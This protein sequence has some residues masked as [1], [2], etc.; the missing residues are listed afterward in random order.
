MSSGDGHS[1]SIELPTAAAVAELLE[2]VRE[3]KV[4][5][6]SGAEEDRT[7][8]SYIEPGPG[9]PR[10]FFTAQELMER[11]HAGS[12]TV[13]QIP[14]FELPCFKKNGKR[15]FWAHVWAYEGR[16]TRE[17]A[18][19]IYHGSLQETQQQLLPDSPAQ[20]SRLRRLRSGELQG[21]K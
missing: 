21:A 14:E 13:Y 9:S 4:M 12:T 3:V 2:E 1:V 10:Q 15:Y 16:I 8:G 7:D 18:D 17:E 6:R 11:W 19:R 5:L 20:P